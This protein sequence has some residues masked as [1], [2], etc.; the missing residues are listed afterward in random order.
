MKNPIKEVLG[1]DLGKTI[2]TKF[3]GKTLV[4]PDAIRVVKRLVDERF[5]GNVI[6]V[7]KVNP[8][9]QRRAEKWIEETQFCKNTGILPRN[10]YF[11]PERQD[12][13]PICLKN[14][15]THFIDDRPEVMSHMEFVTNRILFQPVLEDVVTFEKKLVGVIQ[16]QSWNEIERLLL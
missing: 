11:C 12:K 3:E 2:V 4:F 10:I 6:I 7:S 8:E 9:Q 1:I 13:G 5:R 14:G 15:V 16:V